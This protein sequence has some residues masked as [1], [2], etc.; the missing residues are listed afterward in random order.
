MRA[1]VIDG[2]ESIDKARLTD[3]PDPAPGRGEALLRVI[4][5]A[6]NPADAYLAQGMYPAKPALPHILGRDGLGEVVAIGEGVAHLRIGQKQALLR[7]EAGIN[8]WGTFA[9]LVAVP[10]ESL[11]DIPPGWTDEQ[12]AGATLVYLTAYQAIT[13]WPELPRR[14][15]VLV[16]GASG[17]VGVASTQLAHAMGHT[18]VG[19][20]RDPIKRDR[21]K[22]MGMDLALDPGHPQWKTS[23]RGLLG[24]KRVNLVIDNIGGT[25]FPDLLNTLG[26][27]GRISVV[28][29]LAGAVPE[30]NTASLIF[31]RVRIG[32]VQV[33]AYTTAES[34]AAWGEILKLLA[35]AGA[36]PIVDQVFPFEQLPA[37]FA[38]LA[39]G[40]MGKVLLRV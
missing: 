32:G 36:K 38:R 10:V 31:R 12:A 24:E 33:G 34:R 37:A 35:N 17:G 4:F 39:N 13:Q 2:F 11:V 27:H 26:E 8:R 20:S 23:L 28:G 5:S 15:V 16:S 18:V 40:P 19:L 1:W 22:S 30:F 25:L 6:L 3:V 14:S 7:G 9:E 29:R 21:L